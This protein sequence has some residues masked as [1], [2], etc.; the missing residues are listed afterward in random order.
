MKRIISLFLAVL[1]LASSLSAFSA[2][3][4]TVII[5]GP[6]VSGKC[7]D[8]L[9]WE[10]N[11]STGVLTVS[12]TGDMYDFLGV[13]LNAYN[14]VLHEQVYTYEDFK[15]G[16]EANKLPPW[17]YDMESIKSVIIGEGVT[18]IGCYAFG[19]HANTG[20]VDENRK[21]YVEAIKSCKKL[22]SISLPS[23]LS[24]LDASAF[25]G[26][27]ALHSRRHWPLP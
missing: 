7:G 12:G 23:T 25:Y 2:Y 11:R 10:F 19:F 8:N 22:E 21:P 16:I 3:A 9:T 4:G 13:Q 24:S 27:T 6:P 17:I 1:M 5:D 26:C 14:D 15:P 18:S 20:F